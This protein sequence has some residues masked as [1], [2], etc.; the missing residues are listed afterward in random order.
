MLTLI[1]K[2]EIKII[3]QKIKFYLNQ[4]WNTKITIKVINKITNFL[5][6][7]SIQPAQLHFFIVIC[8]F[9]FHHKVNFDIYLI[10][11]HPQLEIWVKTQQIRRKCLTAVCV[12]TFTKHLSWD[13]IFLHKFCL[14]I[15]KV[16]ISH[17][18]IVFSAS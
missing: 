8:M 1:V 9:F 3:I 5:Q 15:T 18:F 13:F 17:V 4:A 12:I 6:F 16:A 14:F 7:Q 2:L 10:C 11:S